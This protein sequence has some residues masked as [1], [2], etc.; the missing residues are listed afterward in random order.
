MLLALFSIN[1]EFDVVSVNV[2]S[3]VLVTLNKTKFVVAYISAPNVLVSE[4]HGES[5]SEAGRGG[6]GATTVPT[7]ATQ[8]ASR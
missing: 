8:P 4:C 6:R 3:F 2:L 5:Y 7:S 1:F